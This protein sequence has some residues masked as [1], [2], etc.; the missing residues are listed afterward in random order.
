MKSDEEQIKHSGGRPKQSI[1]KDT[2]TG[3][4]LSKLEHFVVKQK[5]SKAGLGISVYIREMALNGQVVA[6]LSEEERQFVRAAL[7]IANNLNQLTMKAHREGALKA[8]L[9]FET[10]R[11]EFD[12]LLKRFKK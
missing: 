6:R 10:Y 1:K 11:N 3:V 9:V 8:L 12:E 4:R 7:G 5:A 2:V